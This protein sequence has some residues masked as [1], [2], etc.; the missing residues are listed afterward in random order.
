MR[1]RFNPRARKEGDFPGTRDLGPA[2]FPVGSLQSRAAARALLLQGQKR[3]ELIFY[4]DKPLK[5]ETSTCERRIWPD[6]TLFAL[7]MLDGRDTDLT[8]AQ[9]EAF[10]QQHPIVDR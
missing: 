2:D 3:Y 9:L 4:T 10:I 8:D 6:G 1:K 5:L 7:V